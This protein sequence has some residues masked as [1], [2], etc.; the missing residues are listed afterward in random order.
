MPLGTSTDFV[1]CSVC[2]GSGRISCYTCGGSGSQQQERTTYDYD[3]RPIYSTEWVSC[4]SCSG[5]S[6]SCSRCGGSGK[7][8][9]PLI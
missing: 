3:N 5:G 4:S 2:G 8:T 9:K 6:K 7:T 1:N